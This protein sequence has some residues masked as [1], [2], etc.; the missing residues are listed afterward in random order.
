MSHVINLTD[1]FVSRYVAL[2][3]VHNITET[4]S[5]YV[6][7]DPSFFLSL[8]AIILAS[9]AAWVD[10]IHRALSAET[11]RQSTKGGG[12]KDLELGESPTT[13]FAESPT[14]LGNQDLDTLDVVTLSANARRYKTQ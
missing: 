11:P 5:T 6:T 14:D 8:G 9:A 2:L 10:P 4:T 12:D 7:K 3:Y 1:G 13:I